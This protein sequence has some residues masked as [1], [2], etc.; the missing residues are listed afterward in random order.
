MRRICGVKEADD[1]AFWMS[2][3][4]AE[5]IFSSIDVCARSAGISD[6]QLSLKEAD[7]CVANCL[8]PAKGCCL[9]CTAFWCCCRGCHHL[10]GPAGGLEV[11]VSIE[12]EEK[13]A[14]DDNLGARGSRLIESAAATVQAI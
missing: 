8:G 7:G 2:W 14:Y 4:D 9:G 10:Y 12:G 11:T 3:T 5:K 13:S 1:G 6:L